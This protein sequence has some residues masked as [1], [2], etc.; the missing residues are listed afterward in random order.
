[1]RLLD[2]MFETVS[3]HDP[4]TVLRLNAAHP[5]YQLHFPGSPVTP[6]VC[7]VKLL[8]ELLQR[9][10][11]RRLELKRIVN[12]KFV[13]PLSPLETSL[14]IVDFTSVAATEEGL[15]AK[16]TI[17]ANDQVATKFSLVYSS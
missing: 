3:H 6:G 8:G 11:D 12:L 15:H 5:I 17:T 2:E 9:K 4:Q 1:M 13:Q 7:L 16:G 14:L 10:L